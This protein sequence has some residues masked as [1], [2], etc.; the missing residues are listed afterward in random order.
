MLVVYKDFVDL[1]YNYLNSCSSPP[2]S[3]FADEV[4]RALK[5]TGHD[6]QARDERKWMV[7]IFSKPDHDFQLTI[8]DPT[9]KAVSFHDFMKQLEDRTRIWNLRIQQCEAVMKVEKGGSRLRK[10]IEP[11]SVAHQ[12][13][14]TTRRILQYP[15]PLTVKGTG[16]D[17]YQTQSYI[18]QWIYLPVTTFSLGGNLALVKGDNRV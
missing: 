18:H 2:I 13:V 8:T 14:Y 9:T 7:A 5:D 6:D 11:A 3:A 15:R 17:S 10:C 4:V 1:P 16:E 12:D